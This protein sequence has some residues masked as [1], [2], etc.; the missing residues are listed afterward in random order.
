MIKT[1]DGKSSILYDIILFELMVIKSRE[2]SFEF[3]MEFKMNLEKVQTNEKFLNY[4]N[5][6]KLPKVHIKDY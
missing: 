2:E 6:Q 4:N 1:D 5:F 3:V